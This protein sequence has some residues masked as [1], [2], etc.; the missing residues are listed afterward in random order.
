MPLLVAPVTFNRVVI[1]NDLVAAWWSR[2]RSDSLG[3]NR[4]TIVV[5]GDSWS[6]T[7]SI[8]IVARTR[9]DAS[10]VLI[11]RVMVTLRPE[12]IGS[13]RPHASGPLSAVTCTDTVWGNS[14]S[15]LIVLIAP[16]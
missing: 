6:I 2:P 4:A 12:G 15:W 8:G 3:A 11:L 5:S 9:C 13:C 1:P 16:T 10:V 14:R 7:C